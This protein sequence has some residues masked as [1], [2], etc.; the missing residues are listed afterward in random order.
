MTTHS[1]PSVM[2]HV[3]L[4]TMGRDKTTASSVGE[5]T[6]A[7]CFEW[8]GSHLD[9]AFRYHTDFS[10]MKITFYFSA[11]CAPI[12]IC[13]NIKTERQKVYHLGASKGE[14]RQ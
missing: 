14:T 12:D 6:L 7:T 10:S 2:T 5:S 13:D 8:L 11:F 9:P 4:R 1:L 3:V